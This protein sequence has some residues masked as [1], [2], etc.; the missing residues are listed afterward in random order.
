MIVQELL[1]TRD[2]RVSA[3]LQRLLNDETVRAAVI[4]LGKL[5]DPSTRPALE[6]F[7]SHPDSWVP[8]EAKKAARKIDRKSEKGTRRKM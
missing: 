5:G 1:K 6:P 2:P 7:L 3:L 4:G 8:N